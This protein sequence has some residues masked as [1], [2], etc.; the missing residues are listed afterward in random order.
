[1][2]LLLC[3][4]HK[5]LSSHARLDPAVVSPRFGRRITCKALALG[6]CKSG[7]DRPEV[8]TTRILAV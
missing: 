3:G 5:L 7:S 2:G 1:M 8:A 6:P 4:R